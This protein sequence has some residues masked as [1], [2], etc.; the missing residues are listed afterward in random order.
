MRYSGEWNGFKSAFGVGYYNDQ[1]EGSCDAATAVNNGTAAAFTACQ[2]S[3]IAKTGRREREVFKYNSSILHVSSGLFLSGAYWR[4]SYNGAALNDN[5]VLGF[6]GGVATQRPDATMSWTAAGIRRNWFG[7]GDT[8]FYGEYSRMDGQ[9]DGTALNLLTPS[10]AGSN[11]TVV[12]D[13]G[14]TKWGFGMIQNIDKAA[15]TLY[16]GYMDYSPE[17]KGCTGAAAPGCA[18]TSQSLENI[19]SVQAGAIVRF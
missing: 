17:A 5:Q 3:A 2:S 19:R 8:T 15:T 6:T 16:I 9:I 12:T 10:G 11:F 4:N 7:I 18:V 14:I 1:D 13:S